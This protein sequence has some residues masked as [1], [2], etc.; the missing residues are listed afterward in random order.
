[1]TT[2][3][4]HHALTGALCAALLAGCSAGSQF[5]PTVGS[6]ESQSAGFQ[7][8]ALQSVAPMHAPKTGNG[9]GVSPDLIMMTYWY[10]INGKVYWWYYNIHGVWVHGEI[11]GIYQGSNLGGSG[12]QTKALDVAMT[13]STVGVYSG[14]KL[15]T[16]LTGLNGVA[17]GVGTDSRGNTFAS[18]NASGEVAV[19][20]FAKGATTPTATYSDQNL[21]SVDS[22]AIDK[23]NHVYVEGQ[24]QAGTIEVDE[25]VGSGRFESLAQSGSGS[26]GATSGG[27]AVQTSGKTTYVWI[28]DRGNASEPANI[29]RYEF[30][31]KSLV[32]LSSF[33]YS[34]IDGAIAVDPAGKDTSDVYAVNN[35]PSGSQYSVSGIEYDSSGQIVSQSPAQTA[36]QESLGIWMK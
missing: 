33:E 5:A 36:S 21:T 2:R 31:G 12:T 4:S 26:L 24:S 18:V 8:A 6:A 11:S 15:V 13:N 16:T 29:S 10:L 1:M 27:L 34:G 28:N 17:A 3:F 30:T 22:L 32:R 20:E 19:E 25:M 35:V 9:H 7:Q 23:A 14:K